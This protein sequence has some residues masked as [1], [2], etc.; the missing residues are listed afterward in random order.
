[1]KYLIDHGADIRAI[2]AEGEMP[3]HFAAAEDQPELI[4]V[5]AQAAADADAEGVRLVS[6]LNTQGATT[7]A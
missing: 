5:L 4:K 3:L 2:E 6:Y 7:G 1:M